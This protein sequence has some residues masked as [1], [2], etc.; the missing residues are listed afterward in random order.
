ML[1]IVSLILKFALIQIRLHFAIVELSMEK[2]KSKSRRM[3]LKDALKTLGVSKDASIDD[4]N[5]AF[6][7]KQADIQRKYSD[8]PERLVKDADV[9]YAAYTTVYESK[10]GPEDKMLALQV[11]GPDS[12]LNMFGINDVP[13]QSLKVQMQTQAQ[14]KDGQLVRK[15]STKTEERII[16]GKKEVKEYENGK[17]IKYTLDGKNML[18]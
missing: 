10:G 3:S 15:E 7:R 13:H 9:L 1:K 11:S 16:D 6:E 8:Q 12:M 18:K 14:Y 2:S 4:I 5:H 17:L